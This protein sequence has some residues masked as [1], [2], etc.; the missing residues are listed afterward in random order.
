MVDWSPDY[1]YETTKVYFNGKEYNMKNKEDR[2]K[3][4][5]TQRQERYKTR[6]TKLM[7]KYGIPQIN[8]WVRKNSNTLTRLTYE[9]YLE[10]ERGIALRQVWTYVMLGIALV[11]MVVSFFVQTAVG[12]LVFLS[13]LAFLF[14]SCDMQTNLRI[15]RLEQRQWRDMVYNMYRSEKEVKD[16]TDE[17]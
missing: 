5:E 17:S 13:A 8:K 9:L 10:E 11:L 4:K 15:D 1:E 6:M 7:D 3:L 14:T 12:S 16:E 2:K